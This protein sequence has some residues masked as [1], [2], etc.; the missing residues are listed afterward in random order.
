MRSI[1]RIGLG[2][3]VL[4]IADLISNPHYAIIFGFIGGAAIFGLIRD[5]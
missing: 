3:T 4:Q 5:V 2:I 1:I